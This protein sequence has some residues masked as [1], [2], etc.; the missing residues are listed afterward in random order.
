M[1]EMNDFMYFCIYHQITFIFKNIVSKCIDYLLNQYMY[2]VR[3]AKFKD[4]ILNRP[5]YYE[6]PTAISLYQVAVIYLAKFVAN[7]G[8]DYYNDNIITFSTD[9][10]KVNKEIKKKNNVNNWYF[11][12]QKTSYS[13]ERKNSKSNKINNTNNE[14]NFLKTNNNDNTTYNIKNKEYSDQIEDPLYIC[15]KLLELI[16]NSKMK[17]VHDISLDDNIY[18]FIYLHYHQNLQKKCHNCKA[19]QS[20][21]EL[22]KTIETFIEILK[23]LKYFFRANLYLPN[24][25]LI[26]RN[27]DRMSKN[28][29]TDPNVIVYK[30]FYNVLLDMEVYDKEVGEYI[31]NF[32]NLNEL[33]NE[34]L[35][36]GRNF[37][38]IDPK[39]KNMFF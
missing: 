8:K 34:A 30:L 25:C 3:I 15:N 29:H 5:Q 32:E 7:N 37:F 20:N 16:Y 21:R 12:K 33:A 31:K 18:K 27:D 13:N 35:K 24:K 9:I 17:D 2:V 1:N 4:P 39:F 14:S 26:Y 22:D 19:C 11:G 6:F 23:L 10:S 38:E 28:L 36:E